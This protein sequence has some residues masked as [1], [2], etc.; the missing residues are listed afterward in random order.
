MSE[1]NAGHPVD[2]RR[3]HADACAAGAARNII[4]VVPLKCNRLAASSVYDV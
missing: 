1:D 3:A 2:T 4:E